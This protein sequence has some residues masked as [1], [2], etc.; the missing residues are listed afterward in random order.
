MSGSETVVFGGGCFWCTQAI[1]DMLKGVLKTTA[2]YAGG[3]LPNPT[4]EDV[5]YKG[6][7]GYVEVVEIKYDPVII[8]FE[9]LLEVFFAMHDPTTPNRQDADIGSQYMSMIFYT[10]Q[11]QKETAIRFI[12]NAQKNYRAPVVT[13]V[14]I[15]EKFYTAEEYHQKYYDKN[16]LHPYCIF[17]TRPK[18]ARIRKEFKE[19]LK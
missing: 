3:T 7:T 1:F 18:V 6:N 15:L 2:G 5:A 17:V 8:S 9:K 13:E 16:P 19:Y 4:Y 12:R 10:T 14:K 11:E